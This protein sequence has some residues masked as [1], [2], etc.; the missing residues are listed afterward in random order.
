MAIFQSIPYRNATAIANMLMATIADKETRPSDRAQL[1]RAWLEIE[2]TKREWR[3]I[4][5][6]SPTSARELLAAKRDQLKLAKTA[7][8]FTDPDDQPTVTAPPTP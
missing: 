2:Q 4:P 1:A 8:S 7:P 3:G 6:L 5:R